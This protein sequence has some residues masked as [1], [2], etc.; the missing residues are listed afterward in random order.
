MNNASLELNVMALLPA[1][2]MVIF[3]LLV[4]L[5]DAFGRGVRRAT[6]R[7]LTPW[8]ALLGVLV[9]GGLCFWLLDQPV[10]LFQG[11]AILDRYA[12]GID[13]VVLAAA[14]LSILV[15]ARYI[16]RVNAQV[17]EYYLSLI[18]ISEP[19]RPY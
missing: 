18:H 11:M 19:T 17:G 5:V 12:L 4:M 6:A 9:T 13:F 7:A 15:S 3:A 16:P 14:G 2:S 10:S 8:V 1:A